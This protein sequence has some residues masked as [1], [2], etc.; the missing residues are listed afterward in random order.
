MN[1]DTPQ[2]QEEVTRA[3]IREELV[4]MAVD[5]RFLVSD[6]EER[7]RLVNY[8]LKMAIKHQRITILAYQIEAWWLEAAITRHRETL[9]SIA[10]IVNSTHRDDLKKIRQEINFLRNDTWHWLG[11]NPGRLPRRIRSRLHDAQLHLA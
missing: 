2:I 6:L 1:I 11:F 5:V 8:Q 9:Q 4:V 7:S 10:D 3:N